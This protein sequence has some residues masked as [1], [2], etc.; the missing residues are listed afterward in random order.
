MKEMP[1]NAVMT[2]NSE[3]KEKLV[4]EGWI[5]DSR[6]GLTMKEWG[7]APDPQFRLGFKMPQM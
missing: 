4:S 3:R 5:T 1:R 7:I 2:E 6:G